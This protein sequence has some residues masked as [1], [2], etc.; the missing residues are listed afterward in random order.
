MFG[1]GINFKLGPMPAPW[2]IFYGI[3]ILKLNLKMLQGAC[4]I[5]WR[6][7]KPACYV[8]WIYSPY[9][10]LRN[11]KLKKLCFDGWFTTQGF[12][13][14]RPTFHPKIFKDTQNTR[15]NARSEDQNMFKWRWNSWE[16]TQQHDMRILY[17]VRITRF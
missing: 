15:L 5:A 11:T 13:L 14:H 10:V 16:V 1:K 2:L 7:F 17:R 4:R 12:V 3:K 8:V 9:Q 6:N